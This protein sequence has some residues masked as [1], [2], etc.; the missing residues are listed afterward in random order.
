MK[1]FGQLPEEPEPLPE[2]DVV[3]P[4]IEAL[5]TPIPPPVIPEEPVRENP[6]ET[7]P[8]PPDS[9]APFSRYRIEHQVPTINVTRP[10]SE[11]VERRQAQGYEDVTG[12]CCKCVIM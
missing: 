5:P 9:P 12:G 6:R 8:K 7:V 1:A 4:L 2:Q 10:S 11:T 3:P